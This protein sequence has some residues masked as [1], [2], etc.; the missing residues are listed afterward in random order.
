MGKVT[1][2]NLTTK[3]HHTHLCF[4]RNRLFGGGSYFLAIH[5]QNQAFSFC[6][7]KMLTTKRFGMIDA[8]TQS[9][10]DYSNTTSYGKFISYTM[11][12]VAIP[13]SQWRNLRFFFFL[14]M[15][16]VHN[17]LQLIAIMFDDWKEMPYPDSVLVE[18]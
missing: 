9:F 18:L 6:R 11:S 4:V 17:S 10:A 8:K 3:M 12:S 14:L 16:I 7:N 1:F 2:G 5:A 13:T 15:T